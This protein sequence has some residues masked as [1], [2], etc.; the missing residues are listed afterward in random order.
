MKPKSGKRLRTLFVFLVSILLIVLLTQLQ[1]AYLHAIGA[2]DG[3]FGL[4]PTT[5]KCVGILLDGK[6]VGENLPQNEWQETFAL[7]KMRYFNR[8]IMPDSEFCLGQDVWRCLA[9]RVRL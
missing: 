4:R 9:E 3:T 8:A 5:H 6:W 2:V 7:F 1:P